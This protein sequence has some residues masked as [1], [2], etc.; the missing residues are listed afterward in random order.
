MENLPRKSKVELAEIAM[1]MDRLFKE[2]PAIIV[3]IIKNLSVE[4]AYEVSRLINTE[5]MKAFETR[6]IW[7]AYAEATLGEETEEYAEII[8]PALKL[9]GPN[10]QINYLWLLLAVKAKSKSYFKS[11]D[12]TISIHRT[13][14]SLEHRFRIVP[15]G[16][17]TLSERIQSRFLNSMS[18]LGIFKPKKKNLFEGLDVNIMID[19]GDFLQL[20][21]LIMALPGMKLYYKH[22]NTKVSWIKNKI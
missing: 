2:Q 7:K 10:R 12:F 3:S 18:T 9:L 11:Q 16:I 5:T 20:F 21:Y 22:E 6:N 8:D 1:S 15:N 14:I 13:Q 4:E 17:V 19:D